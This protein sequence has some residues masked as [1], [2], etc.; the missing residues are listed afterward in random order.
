MLKTSMQLRLKFS[1]LSLFIIVAVTAGFVAA[2][3]RPRYHFI[4]FGLNTRGD[5]GDSGTVYG[6]PCGFITAYYW[7]LGQQPYSYSFTVLPLLANIGIFVVAVVA[8][9]AVVRLLVRVASKL[10]HRREQMTAHW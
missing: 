8:A 10:R 3:L 1:I 9:I 6:W 4:P 5:S 2:N 7:D